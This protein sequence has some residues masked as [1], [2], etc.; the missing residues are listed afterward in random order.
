M[1]LQYDLKVRGFPFTRKCSTS[2]T[3]T[4]PERTLNLFYL[5]RV[6]VAFERG[7]VYSKLE[8]T[9]VY[10][11]NSSL[12]LSTSHS[13]LC[14]LI[15][16]K[17]ITYGKTDTFGRAAERFNTLIPEPTKRSWHHFYL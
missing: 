4:R 15:A 7:K 9:P 2:A 8:Y 17:N 14:P 12:L 11:L 1:L 5:S 10:L 6:A 3:N 16:E 13:S